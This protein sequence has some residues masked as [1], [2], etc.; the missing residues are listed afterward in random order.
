[1]EGSQLF[2]VITA[3]DSGGF[4]KLKRS[5]RPDGCLADLWE[6]FA[7]GLIYGGN[8]LADIVAGGEN[9]PVL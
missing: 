4:G 7:N 8:E 3:I 6:M 9:A 2:A 5:N 1:M